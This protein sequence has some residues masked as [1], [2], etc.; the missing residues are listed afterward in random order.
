MSSAFLL[1]VMFLLFQKIQFANHCMFS[2][3][4]GKQTS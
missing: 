2:L 4:G 1:A 3:S